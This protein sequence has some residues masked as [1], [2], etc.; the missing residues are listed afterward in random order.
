MISVSWNDDATTNLVSTFLIHDTM[1]GLDTARVQEVVRVGNVTP[2]H[3]APDHII[4]I[5]NLRGKIVTVLDLGKKLLFEAVTITDESRIIILDA[6]G[7]YVGLLVD[8][9]HDVLPIDYSQVVSSPGNI[10]ASQTRYFAGVYH[11]EGQGLVTLL[12]SEAV[13]SNEEN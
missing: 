9:V 8:S 1:Y 5:I 10:S 11:H 12:D 2:V 3:H 6:K 13:L 7:E 4:G